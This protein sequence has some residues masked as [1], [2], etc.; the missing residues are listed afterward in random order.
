MPRPLIFFNV[1]RCGI[2]YRVIAAT[3]INDPRSGSI[4][5]QPGEEVPQSQTLDGNAASAFAARLNASF[6]AAHIQ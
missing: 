2:G 1:D 4:L 3:T 6:R 5:Y